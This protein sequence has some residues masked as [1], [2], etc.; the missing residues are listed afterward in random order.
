MDDTHTNR[1]DPKTTETLPRRSLRLRVQTGV[2]TAANKLDR[3]LIP[4]SRRSHPRKHGDSSEGANLSTAKIDS[5]NRDLRVVESKG[6]GGERE[7]QGKLGSCNAP[8]YE[9]PSPRDG[10]VEGKAKIV[11]YIYIYI[12]DGIAFPLKDEI[13]PVLN[14]WL[15]LSG[16][17]LEREARTGRGSLS[18]LAAGKDSGVE[19]KS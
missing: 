1:R 12:G 17:V 2:Q 19:V 3:N 11:L 14:A 10:L 18:L 4:S 15:K 16:L 9:L 13:I 8:R 5:R 6:E 7:D